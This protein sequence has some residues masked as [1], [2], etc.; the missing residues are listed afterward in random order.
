MAIEGT[1]IAEADLTN[2]WP[3]EVLLQVFDDDRDGSLDEGVTTHHILTAESRVEQVLQKTY[4]PGGLTS[5]RAL[6]AS[7][8][9]AVK[10]MILDVFEVYMIRRH[11]EYIRGRWVER[12]KSVMADLEALRVRELEL[13]NEGAAPEPAVN[14]GGDVRSGDPDNTCPVPPAYTRGMGAY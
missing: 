1:Y 14:E 3:L 2:R 10:R 8:P 9:F 5:L 7:A 11:P 6:G 4:G 13:D 12:E